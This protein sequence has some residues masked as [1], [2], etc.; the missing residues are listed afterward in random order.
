LSE[1]VRK[2]VKLHRAL[3]KAKLPHAFGGALALAW[4]TER[5]RG[6]IDIDVNVFVDAAQFRDVVAALPRGVVCG[7]AEVAALERD[8]QARLWWDRTPVD[9]FLDTTPYHRGAFARCREEH[10]GGAAIP[11]LSCR[12]IAVFK[13][14]YNRTKDWADLEEMQAA[15]TL[16]ID[17]VAAVLA[18]YLGAEDDRIRKLVALRRTPVQGGEK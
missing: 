17:K 14:F 3:E 11:F 6:T 9:V 5:A 15:G 8:G 13:A 7:D 10:F 2:I 16:E 12:D 4:C 18:E 1:L